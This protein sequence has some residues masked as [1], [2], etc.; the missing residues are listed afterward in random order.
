MTT[1]RFKYRRVLH[2]SIVLEI[3]LINSMG[4]HQRW[5]SLLR[6]HQEDPFPQRLT[7]WWSKLVTREGIPCYLNLF[8]RK[9]QKTTYREWQST[10]KIGERFK[11]VNNVEVLHGIALK[12]SPS[13]FLSFS[14]LHFTPL[15]NSSHVS[16]R[17]L[18]RHWPTNTLRACSPVE[19]KWS[20]EAE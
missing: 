12:V 8:I 14:L 5:I 16:P 2:C 6:N 7:K 10:E 1:R 17:T 11:K 3:K 15:F 9:S 20:V 18:V 19:T 4:H 13:K